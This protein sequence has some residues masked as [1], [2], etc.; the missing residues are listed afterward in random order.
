MSE[1]E[2]LAITR[3]MN[4]SE[5]TFVLPPSK[6]GA[7][8]RNR[9]FTPGGELPF[10]GHPSLG[11]AYVAAMEGIVP[12]RE[13][14]STVHQEVLIGVLP[15]ELHARGGIIE[16]VVMTQGKPTVGKRLT[17][18][19]A[20]AKALGIRA[21]DITGTK[22]VP[23]VASTGIRSLQVPV[24]S[25]KVVRG[26]EPDIPALAKVLRRVEPDAGAYVFAFQAEGDADLH[27]RGFFPLSGNPEDPATGSA[28]GACGAYLAA[29]RRLPAKEWFIIE[30]GIEVHHPS[31]IEVSV[32]M[33]SGRS[34]SVRVA[35]KVVPVMQ[36]TLTLP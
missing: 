26:M 16:R 29:N 23:Q 33:A 27:A 35:G 22:L 28:A 36:G 30:Q 4:I 15:L 31:R 5:T 12:L 2:M 10:A 3:E 6:A 14:A 32:A 20:L 7:N 19:G 18:T 34:Q 1:A 9:I 17:A 25:M 13:G 8:Y 24:R 11:T 21:M